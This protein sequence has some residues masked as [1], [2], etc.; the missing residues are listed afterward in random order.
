MMTDFIS[1]MLLL[2]PTASSSK[3][4]G[5]KPFG[6]SDLRMNMDELRDQTAAI[7]SGSLGGM[8]FPTGDDTHQSLRFQDPFT[9]LPPSELM[10]LSSS[11]AAKGQRHDRH[12]SSGMGIEQCKRL[13]PVRLLRVTQG[14]ANWSRSDLCSR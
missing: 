8:P 4:T 6:V 1:V 11:F 7:E 13:Q 3:R 5:A 9:M 2:S 10:R 12:L 14:M